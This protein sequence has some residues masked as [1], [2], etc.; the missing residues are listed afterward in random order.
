[1]ELAFIGDIHLINPQD[2]RQDLVEKRSFFIEG[3]PSLLELIKTLE[4]RAVDRIIF[5]GDIVDWASPDNIAFAANILK[6]IKVPWSI[7]PGNHDYQNPNSETDPRKGL[8]LRAMWQEH[9]IS[10]GEDK[11]DCGPFNLFL[12]DN[13][14]GIISDESLAWLK[15]ELNEKPYNIVAQHVPLDLPSIRESIKAVTPNRNLEHYTCSKHTNLFEDYYKGRVQAVLTGHVHMSD[16]VQIDDCTNYLCNVGI[17]LSDPN[18]VEEAQ[19]T[20]RLLR[21]ND[22]VFESEIIARSE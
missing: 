20:A 2:A 14:T 12:V 3:Q 16:I 15:T 1:M 9:G 6:E 19:C 4:Q 8:E 21:F 13:A 18:R 22:G 5:L 11:I 10:M 7:A 17:K